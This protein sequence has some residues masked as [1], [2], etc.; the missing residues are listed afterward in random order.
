MDALT[1]IHG[2]AGMTQT[3]KPQCQ[4]CGADLRTT[5]VDLGQAPLSNAFVDPAKQGAPDR[6][7]PLHARVCDK[8]FLVQVENCVPPSDI[9]SDYAYFS[10]YSKSW[11]AHAKAYAEKMID[12]FHLTADDE[13]IE[14]ASNDGYMLKNFVEK[15]IPVLGVEPAANI[16]KTAI[17]KGINTRIAF[18]GEQTARDLKAEG[19]APKLIAAKNVMAHVPDINDFV[20]GLAVL[21]NGDAVFTVEFP[22]LLNLI[23][24]VQFDTIYHEHFTYLSLLAVENILERHGL[25][26]F[27]VEEVPTHGGSLRVFICT[28]NASHANCPGVAAIRSTN[29][30][31]K[32]LKPAPINVPLSP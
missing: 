1:Q 25:R 16:A 15:G 26:V 21:L 4:N 28:K 12:R 19:H 3:T 7:Y 30:C 10:S 22:H 32:Y 29:R 2:D 14:I 23:N 17:E 8:C 13:V 9:F 6:R 18:F 24:E 20:A 31:I 5:L 11:L 27:D